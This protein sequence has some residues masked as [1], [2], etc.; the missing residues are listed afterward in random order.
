[1][2]AIRELALA[3]A[4][5]GGGGG[6]YEEMFAKVID[7]TVE[8]LVIP[9]GV[10]KVASYAFSDCRKVKSVVIP[11]SVKEFEDNSF[12]ML[13]ANNGGVKFP[14]VANGVETIGGI[15]SGVNVFGGATYVSK[16]VLPKAKT[17]R[18]GAFSGCTNTEYIYIGAACTSIGSGAFGG[19]PVTCKVE[20]GFAE[21]A[22]SGFPSS[23]GWAGNPAGLDITYNVAEPSE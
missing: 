11:D 16:I 4:T 12:S 17:I 18:A 3:K 15:A 13:G 23:G 22:V 8:D 19:V 7:R 2:S 9:D 1:M 14:V 5:G 10:K 20:V 6:E 21:G